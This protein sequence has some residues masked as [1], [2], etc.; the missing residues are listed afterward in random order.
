VCI[1]RTLC[2]LYMYMCIYFLFNLDMMKY[3]LDTYIHAVVFLHIYM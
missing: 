3:D 1:E 2:I